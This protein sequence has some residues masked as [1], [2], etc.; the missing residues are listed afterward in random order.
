MERESNRF[1]RTVEE[2]GVWVYRRDSAR[3]GGM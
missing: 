1:W 2:E 3:D